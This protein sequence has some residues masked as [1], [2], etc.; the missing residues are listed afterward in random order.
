MFDLELL[1]KVDLF[2]HLDP[3]QLA[4]VR[5]AAHVK[6]IPKDSILFCEGDK[7]DTLYLILEGRV[8]ATLLAEDGR[9]VILSTIGAGELVGEMAVFDLEETRSATVITVEDSE[10]LTLSGQQFI[11]VMQENPT[12]ALSVIRSLT[13]RLKD[14][15]SRIGNLVFLDTY[16]RVGRYLVELGKSSGRY[17]AD[18]SL[19]VQRP[20]H[21]EIANYIGTTRETVSR[22]LKELEHQGLI[23]MVGRNVILYRIRK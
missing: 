6:R 11:K 8:K 1:R 13:R 16:A 12:I 18:G 2:S 9:E 20:T 22:T 14:A 21:Q 3:K 10:L 17:L 5:A 7:G 15:S 23:R 19:L 4:A